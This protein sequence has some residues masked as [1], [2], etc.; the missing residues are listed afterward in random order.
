MFCIRFC[1]FICFYFLSSNSETSRQNLDALTGSSKAVTSDK[2]QSDSPLKAQLGA[3]PLPLHTTLPTVSQLNKMSLR[4]SCLSC[5]LSKCS[6]LKRQG[7]SWK[8][9]GRCYIWYTETC[10]TF[11][12]SHVQWWI[13]FIFPSHLTIL[14]CPAIP[15]RPV[16][17]QPLCHQDHSFVAIS[18]IA[19]FQLENRDMYVSESIKISNWKMILN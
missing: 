3:L 7:K 9:S 11:N 6:R 1:E 15:N 17:L 18:I 8:G 14:E 16:V 12:G 10:V 4:R 13:K 2:R 5:S 19:M